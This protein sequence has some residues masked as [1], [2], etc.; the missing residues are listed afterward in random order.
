[1]AVRDVLV[2]LADTAVSIGEEAEDLRGK[3]GNKEN[4]ILGVADLTNQFIEDIE[5]FLEE[6]G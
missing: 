1:M 3:T 2:V 6:R 4:L 5:D